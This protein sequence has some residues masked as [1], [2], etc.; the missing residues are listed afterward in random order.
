MIRFSVVGSDRIGKV[1]PATIATNPKAR[2]AWLD[3]LS[4]K[5]NREIPLMPFSASCA[6]VPSNDGMFWSDY[7]QQI[8]ILGKVQQSL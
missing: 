3:G 6:M 2:K 7:A 5:E 4:P 1:H 8:G